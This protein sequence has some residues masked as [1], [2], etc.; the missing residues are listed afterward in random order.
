MQDIDIMTRARL[1]ELEY[2]KDKPA[3]FV[4]H[5]CRIESKDGPDP[6]IPFGLWPGQAEALESIA[7]HKLSIIL[8][9]RQLG[10]TW[11]AICYAIHMMLCKPGATVIVISRTEDEA[12]EI[13]RRAGVVLSHMPEYVGPLYSMRPTSLSISLDRDGELPRVIKAFPASADAGRSF[14]ADLIILDEWGFQQYAEAIWQAGFPTINRPGGGQVIGLSTM[15]L[16]TLFADLWANSAVFNKIFLPWDTDPRRDID[17][18]L[19]TKAV[20]GEAIYSEYPATPDEALMMPAGAFFSEFRRDL[21]VTE[22]FDIPCDWRRYHM[23]DYGLDMLASYWAAFDSEGNCYV[24]REL[25]QSDMTIPAASK[26]MLEAETG[27]DIYTRYAPPD[28]FGRSQ[29]SGRTRDEIFAQNGV[30]FT[31]SSNDREAGWANVK[32]WLK[33]ERDKTGREYT[34]LMIFKTCP[35]LIRTLQS[36]PR[37]PKRPNDCAKEPHELTHAPDALRYLLVM[38]PKQGNQTKDKRTEMYYREVEDF[39]SYGT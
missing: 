16:G 32:D 19:Q 37:D 1:A 11:L 14:T 21:H 31:K 35:N 2:C 6:I 27:D 34:K 30:A 20:L 4:R 3:Y 5:Y 7:S 15:R 13:I 29:E 38:R 22:P 28:I 24:Y 9:A 33:V 23:M 36:I 18:Y 39:L 25:Y 8:K 26:A 12:K 17:W 10:I